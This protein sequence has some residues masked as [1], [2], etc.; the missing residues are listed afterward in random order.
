VSQSRKTSGIHEVRADIHIASELLNK[1]ESKQFEDLVY[2]H[3]YV[4][5][6]VDAYLSVMRRD[7]RPNARFCIEQSA[8][9][10]DIG[11]VVLQYLRD[12]R[13]ELHTAAASNVWLALAG[14]YPCR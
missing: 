7:R 14:A 2:C 11:R 1:C 4:A 8:S 5:G 12:N 13:A 10:S 9:L 3:G 6:V